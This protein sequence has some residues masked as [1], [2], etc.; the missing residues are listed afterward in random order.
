MVRVQLICKNT[1]TDRVAKTLRQ[2][3]LEDRL[4]RRKRTGHVMVEFGGEDP[5][6]RILQECRS[7]SYAYLRLVAWERGGGHER[8]GDA[9]CVAGIEGQPL[10]SIIANTVGSRKSECANREHV[11]FGSRQGLTIANVTRQNECVTM[12]LTMHRMRDFKLEPVVEV[13]KDEFTCDP[14]SWL[15][16][17]H[18]KHADLDPF[19]PV[20]RAAL[21]KSTCLFC[22]HCHYQEI[23]DQEES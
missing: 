18:V 17:F 4:G 10:R 21:R 11:L 14:D 6:D 7:Y 3:E 16:N 8:T 20:M 2:F 22:T 13:L 9:T 19:V 12:S 5:T 1:N 15:S 23:P